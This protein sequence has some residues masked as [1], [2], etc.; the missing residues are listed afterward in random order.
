M[1]DPVQV[2]PIV[3]FVRHR[4][5]AA[6]DVI[7]GAGVERRPVEPG[8]SINGRTPESLL[9]RVREWHKEL[10]KDAGAPDVTWEPADIGWLTHVE[11]DPDTD[12]TRLWTVRELTSRRELLAEGRDLRHCVASY[13]DSCRRR[14][15]SIWS[16]GVQAG[17]R[18]KRLVT[19]EVRNRTIVQVRGKA[20]RLAG[21]REWPLL[22]KWAAQER[23]TI[24]ERA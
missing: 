1:L 22:R 15:C 21:E 12:E 9:R 3:D 10:G 19:V 5:F 6:E 8:F 24:P 20:N 11:R 17:G 14:F 2:G 4:K 7:V 13:A 23:L 18:R 16:L